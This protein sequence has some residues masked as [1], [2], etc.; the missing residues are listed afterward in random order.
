MEIVEERA[1]ER[2]LER[3]ENVVMSKDHNPD[4]VVAE[5]RA[6][7][8]RLF[9]DAIGLHYD[10]DIT[11]P[12]TIAEAKAGKIKGMSFGMYNVRDE[13]EQRT[14]ELP[15]R[16]IKA[17]DLDHITLVVRKYPVYASTS[18]ELRANGE[19]DMET[20]G[21]EETIETILEKEQQK[22]DYSDMEN[23]LKLIKGE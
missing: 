6:G 19:I 23:R 17:L 22:P 16:H 10:A 7:S 14:D 11:D 20:R 3:A 5:T 18:V 15:I 9:E 1:F 21:M 8:L 13:I 2:A 12:D 4:T